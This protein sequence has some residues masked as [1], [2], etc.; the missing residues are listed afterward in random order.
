MFI[1]PTVFDNARPGRTIAREE[2]F[3]PVTAILTARSNKD[4][5][6]MANDA[7]YCLQATLFTNNLSRGHQYAKALRAGTVSV[8]AYSEGDN[9]TPFGGYK[10]VR[11]WRKGQGARIA[12]PVF[13]NQ[14][15][16]Y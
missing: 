13:G 2:I 3:G 5:M 16:F 10:L 11:L 14:D 4:A 9:S 15:D 6:R 7:C 8:N 1:A 12:R